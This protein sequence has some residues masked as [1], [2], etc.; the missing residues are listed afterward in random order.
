MELDKIPGFK[1]AMAAAQA[2]EAALRDVPYLGLPV[3]IC[4][5]LVNQITPRHLIIL[6][7]C[8]SPF[9]CKADAIEAEHVAQFLWVLSPRFSHDPAERDAFLAD[10]AGLDYSAAVERIDAYLA[11]AFMDSPA[12]G[13]ASKAPITSFAAA[14]VDELAHEYGWPLADILNLPMA[15]IYQQYR[16]IEQRRNSKAVFFSRLSDRTK[17]ELVKKFLA[18]QKKRGATA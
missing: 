11:E 6:F 9:F 13:G 3:D 15:A 1:E 8:R 16:R 17:R 14:I 10:I 18:D 2:E 12:S 7:N 5:V 4:G